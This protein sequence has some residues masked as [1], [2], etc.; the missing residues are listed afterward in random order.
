MCDVNIT[1]G[2]LPEVRKPIINIPMNVAVPKTVFV[3]YILDNKNSQNNPNNKE[4][5]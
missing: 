3:K 2:I 4:I 1:I 5:G